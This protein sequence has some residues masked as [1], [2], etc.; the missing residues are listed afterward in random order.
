[1]SLSKQDQLKVYTYVVPPKRLIRSCVKY[2][3]LN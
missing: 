3:I 2:R 1:M